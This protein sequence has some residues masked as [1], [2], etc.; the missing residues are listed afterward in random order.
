MVLEPD[1]FARIEGDHTVF[2]Q[3]PLQ[4]L[5]VDQRL[6]ARKHDGFWAPLDTLRDKIFLEKLWESGSAP[7]KVWE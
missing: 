4:S 3:Q 7:W 2:E 1:V 5:A 6:G